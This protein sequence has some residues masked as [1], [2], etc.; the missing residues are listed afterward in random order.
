MEG[1][2]LYGLIIIGGVSVLALLVARYSLEA[3]FDTMQFI[4]VRLEKSR[5]HK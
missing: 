4:M 3:V 1:I 2:G 5:H